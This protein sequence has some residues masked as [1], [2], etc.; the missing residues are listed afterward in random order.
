MQN[1]I[2]QSKQQQ[3]KE[4][5]YWEVPLFLRFTFPVG[6]SLCS[7]SCTLCWECISLDQGI[8]IKSVLHGSQHQRYNKVL[9]DSY[10][11]CIYKFTKIWIDCV[12]MAVC[13]P[14]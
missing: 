7:G 4:K 12:Q 8:S 9:P 1:K 5:S 2:K 6:R 10:S 3:Q 11:L 13:C 14:V